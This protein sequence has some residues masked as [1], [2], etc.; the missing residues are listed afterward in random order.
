M[1]GDLDGPAAPSSAFDSMADQ[2]K[3]I[4]VMVNIVTCQEF[5]ELE[6]N[7]AQIKKYES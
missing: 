4:T 7:V 1:A 5:S 6:E 3:K 2:D